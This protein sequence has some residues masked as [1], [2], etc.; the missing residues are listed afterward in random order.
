MKCLFQDFINS[1]PNCSGLASSSTAKALFDFLSQDIIT[2]KMIEYAEIGKPAL[3]GCVSEFEAFYD[4]I[5]NPDMSLN[6][7]FNKQAVGRMIKTILEPFGYLPTNQK[8]FSKSSGTKYFRSA[9]CYSLT[10]PA[11]LA[12]VKQIIETDSSH[13]TGC[14]NEFCV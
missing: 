11:Y 9:K 10:G 1:N 2:I 14:N 4:S 12:V 7:D 13:R 3:A 8:A 6:D 5:S